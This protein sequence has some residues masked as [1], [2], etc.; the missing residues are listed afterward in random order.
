MSSDRVTLTHPDLPG[1][2][3]TRSTRSVPGLLARGWV[4]LKS[5]AAPAVAN[6]TSPEGDCNPS[7]EEQ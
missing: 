6:P 4:E 1:V 3:I 7:E 2:E 5:S